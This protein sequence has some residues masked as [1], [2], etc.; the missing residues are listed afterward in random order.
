VSIPILRAAWT[1]AIAQVT[2]TAKRPTPTCPNGGHV[3]DEW[4]TVQINRLGADL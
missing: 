3:A 2:G 1:R 4:L